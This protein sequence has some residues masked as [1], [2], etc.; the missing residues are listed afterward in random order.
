MYEHYLIYTHKIGNKKLSVDAMYRLT[1]KDGK[2]ILSKKYG[3]DDV[4]WA[5]TLIVRKL[6]E[7]GAHKRIVVYK[8]N[9]GSYTN[10]SKIFDWY[11]EAEAEKVQSIGY[12]EY[13][14]KRDELKA[15]IKA[16]QAELAELDKTWG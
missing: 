16:L 5:V 1:A 14:Q 8:C 15:K 10:K 4:T 3:G 13:K 12:A 7:S 6:Q 11:M 9:D 2:V